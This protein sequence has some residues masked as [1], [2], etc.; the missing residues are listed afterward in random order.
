MEKRTPY[1]QRLGDA[2]DLAKMGVAEEDAMALLLDAAQRIFDVERL[3][4]MQACIFVWNSGL[5]T[6]PW[7]FEIRRAGVLYGTFVDVPTGYSTRLQAEMQA[8]KI[9]EAMIDGTFQETYTYLRSTCPRCKAKIVQQSGEC[10][11]CEP[12]ERQ[13]NSDESGIIP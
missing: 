13:V 11:V 7:M 10:V 3:D 1:F 6:N 4:A 9:C 5:G 2:I 8:V 12:M